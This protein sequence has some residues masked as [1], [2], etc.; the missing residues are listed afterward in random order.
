MKVETFASQS[1][2]DWLNFILKP[3][4]MPLQNRDLWRDFSLYVVVVID[5]IW[6][7]RN[8]VVHQQVPLDLQALLVTIRCRYKEHFYA[9]NMPQSTLPRSWDP[10]DLDTL[11]I[12]FDAAV[13]QHI[14]I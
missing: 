5:S 14:L 10:P 13:S 1:V 4:N 6:L 2:S 9:W 12:N 8:E 3:Q 11:K 7:C